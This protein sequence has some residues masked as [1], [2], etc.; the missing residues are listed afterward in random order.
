MVYPLPFPILLYIIIISVIYTVRM[1]LTSLLE[2]YTPP[3][4]YTAILWIGY[5]NSV[6]NPFVY[7]FF[8]REFRGVIL[9]DYKR[10]SK[11]R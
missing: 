3:L 9:K 4:L 10:F 5:G 7:G 1:P 6:V 11:R 8:S 2:L